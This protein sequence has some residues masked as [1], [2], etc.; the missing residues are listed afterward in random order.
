M[1]H[2]LG[3]KRLL[4]RAEYSSTGDGSCEH[5]RVGLRSRVGSDPGGTSERV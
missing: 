4:R 2:R 1:L 5:V 3:F